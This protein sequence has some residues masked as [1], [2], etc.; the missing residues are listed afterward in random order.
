[1]SSTDVKITDFPPELLVV[2][3]AKAGNWNIPSVGSAFRYVWR[4]RVCPSEAH[5]ADHLLAASDGDAVKAIKSAAKNTPVQGPFGRD[6]VRILLRNGSPM[7]AEPDVDWLE[8]A[9][10]DDL[11]DV[12]VETALLARPHTVIIEELLRYPRVWEDS[13]RH[14]SG[15]VAECIADVFQTGNAD[16]MRSLVGVAPDACV[17]AV[18]TQWNMIHDVSDVARIVIAAR[19]VEFNSFLKDC[20]RLNYPMTADVLLQCG[21]NAGFVGH[22]LPPAIIHGYSAMADLLLRHGFSVWEV[23]PYVLQAALGALQASTLRRL[24]NRLALSVAQMDDLLVYAVTWEPT[25]VSK[26][27]RMWSFDARRPEDRW[28]RW[29]VSVAGLRRAL[30]TAQALGSRSLIGRLRRAIGDRERKFAVRCVVMC[31]MKKKERKSPVL[32]YN[33]GFFLLQRLLHVL[34][35]FFAAWPLSLSLSLSLSLLLSRQ[36]LTLALTA[37]RVHSSVWTLRQTTHTHTKTTK[38][39]QHS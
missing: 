33:V 14:P 3:L 7:D 30:D 29:Y 31:A 21:V 24:V 28:R 34:C 1:M 4:D 23:T 15:C 16:V 19:P 11:R 25:A 9:K 8:D 26:L 20:V 27:V 36:I 6:V 39:H 35:G 37:A 12:V 22:M 32:P 2:M 17:S 10:M 38:P 18:K 5:W 13:E